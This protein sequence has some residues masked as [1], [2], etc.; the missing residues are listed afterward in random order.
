M[1]D[2][3]NVKKVP[4]S[5]L[6]SSIPKINQLIEMY[7]IENAANTINPPSAPAEK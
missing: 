3:P 2:A 7:I 1:T 5:R 6:V 4:L